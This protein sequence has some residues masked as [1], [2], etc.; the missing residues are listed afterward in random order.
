MFNKIKNLGKAYT[1][2][3]ISKA[4]V[5][6]IDKPKTAKILE[7]GC[8]RGVFLKYLIE[9]GF[10][11]IYACEIDKEDYEI[12]NNLYGNV[13]KI[14][15][16]DYLIYDETGFDVVIGNPPYVRWQNITKEDKEILKNDF[17]KKYSNGFWDLKYAFIIESVEKLKENGYLIFLVPSIWMQLT[18]AKSVR[19]YLE[20]HGYF[21][22]IIYFGDAQIFKG[23]DINSFIIMYYVKT[24]DIKN[25]PK[26]EII[27]LDD[28]NKL[29]IINKIKGRYKDFYKDW[30]LVFLNPDIEKIPYKLK[31][32]LNVRVGY[33][34]GYHEAFEVKNSIK[35]LDKYEYNFAKAKNCKRYVL[36]GYKKYY[37]FDEIEDI[38]DPRN[39]VVKTYIEKFKNKLLER[40]GL[41]SDKWWKW[42]DNMKKEIESGIYEKE[43]IIAP[44]RNY[45]GESIFSYCDGKMF[46]GHDAIFLYKKDETKEDLKYFLAWL[47]TKM[48][49]EW[50][51]VYEPKS[52]NVIRYVQGKTKMIPVIPINWDNEEEVKIYN[53]IIKLVDMILRNSN[54]KNN[55][56][57]IE[58]LFKQLIKIKYR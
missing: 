16:K 48:V 45:S 15:L 9:S 37:I 1:P 13:A 34:S 23:M 55:E 29:E 49:N 30:S 33:V 2:D 43:K 50:C 27:E 8:G 18:N 53:K 38:N 25:I 56:V 28:P 36:D 52:G 14:E 26:T 24:S 22:K 42:V 6:L 10:K 47:N 58:N 31:D 4:M 35:D 17:W 44:S 21:K 5:S 19:K 46:V 7:P 20:E 51:Q 57:K 3:I 32:F 41:K 12:S 11:N 39:N 40:K 54:S